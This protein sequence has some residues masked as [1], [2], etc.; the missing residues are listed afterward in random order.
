[1]KHAL[2]LPDHAEESFRSLIDHWPVRVYHSARLLDEEVWA[3]RHHGLFSLSED[4]V[5]SRIRS[6]CA[7]GHL[8]T[9]ERDALLSSSVFA[10]GNITGRYG[11]VCAVAGRRIFDDD[12]PAIELLLCLWGGEAIY[13][14]H[15]STAL[16]ERLRDLGKPAVV[17]VNLNFATSSRPPFFAPML[18]K[19]F[20]GKILRLNR[21]YGDVYYYGSVMPQDIVDIW[22]PGHRE[23]DRHHRL[24]QD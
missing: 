10:S 20:V 4:L 9:A 17:V 18:A 13:W 14:A 24:P 3:I 16:G 15:E 12:P 1:L 7:S 23:Y 11:Q 5:T 21:S 22:Q 19:L 6:A 2:A 8:S